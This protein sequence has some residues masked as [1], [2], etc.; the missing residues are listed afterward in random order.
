MEETCEL[1]DIAYTLFDVMEFFSKC[2]RPNRIS[3]SLELLQG[4][5]LYF[6]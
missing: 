6:Y 3:V 1:T 4:S 5:K 2:D